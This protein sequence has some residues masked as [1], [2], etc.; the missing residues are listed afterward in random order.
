MPSS[1]N[2]AQNSDEAAKEKKVQKNATQRFEESNVSL[3]C[4]LHQW[5]W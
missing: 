4:L 5:Q 3:L 1:K 2:N